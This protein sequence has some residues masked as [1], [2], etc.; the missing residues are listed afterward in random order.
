[1]TENENSAKNFEDAVI[2]LFSATLISKD[3]T[4]S[5]LMRLFAS[6]CAPQTTSSATRCCGARRRGVGLPQKDEAG[7][8]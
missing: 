6:L 1:L 4:T 3:R 7:Q 2:A 5:F 8:Y